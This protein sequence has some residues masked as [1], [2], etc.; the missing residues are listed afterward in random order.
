MSKPFPFAPVAGALL[1]AAAPFAMAQSPLPDPVAPAVLGRPVDQIKPVRPSHGKPVAVTKQAGLKL[2]PASNLPVPL[3][4]AA[5]PTAAA[6][7]PAAV[8]AAPAAP[9]ALAAAPHGAKQAL[10]DRFDPNARLADDVGKGTHLATK[11]L[12]SGAYFSSRTQQM[13]RNYYASHPGP[14]KSAGW[15]IGEPVPPKAVMSGVPDD[16]RAGLPRLPPG[17]Q[18]V[19]IDGEVVLVALPSRMVVDGVSRGG[20]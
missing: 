15:K 3:A 10:D 20:S 1:L 11:P 19:Q 6:L 12:P 16:V 9:A 17:H 8:Q 14:A 4:P 7:M 5:P 18:Y 2:V 13:V